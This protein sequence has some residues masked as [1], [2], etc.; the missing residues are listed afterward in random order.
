MVTNSSVMLGWNL[1]EMSVLVVRYLER[2]QRTAVIL[3]KSVPQFFFGIFSPMKRNMQGF[4]E[5][6][7]CKLLYIST[8][9][10]GVIVKIQTYFS[11]KVT[12]F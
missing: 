1:T 6:Y 4:Y 5:Y 2:P 11:S 3:N 12:K 8:T 7:L 10:T 9:P